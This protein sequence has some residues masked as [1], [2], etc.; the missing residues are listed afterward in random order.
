M[1][2]LLSSS[3]DKFCEQ[4]GPRSGLTKW[5]LLI[6]LEAFF[7]KD[8]HKTRKYEKI[9]LHAKEFYSLPTSVVC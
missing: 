9:T 6:F 2:T 4:F 8:Q 1:Q 7:E 3:V 5:T